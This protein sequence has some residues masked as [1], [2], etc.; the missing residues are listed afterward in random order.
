[1]SLARII[2]RVQPLKVHV[3]VC[4]MLVHVPKHIN[5]HT[6]CLL[7][8]LLLLCNLYSLMS[9][10]MLF[11]LL[12]AKGIVFP[13]LMT[14][15]SLLEYTYSIT[16]QRFTSI[17]LSFRPLL[18]TCLITKSSPFNL[19]GVGNMSISIPYSAKL[20]SLIKSLVLTPI[21]KTGML[22]ASTVI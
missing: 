12:G 7:V 5:Y 6:S 15:V 22:S 8:L 19:I 3:L 17:S 20:A 14:I 18:N 1:V 10:V 4:V 9:G 13:L 16:N 11:S 21:N 2:Y